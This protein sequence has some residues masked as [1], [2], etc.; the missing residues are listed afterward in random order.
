MQKNWRRGQES[1]LPPD[2]K[3]RTSGFE[4]RDD[5]QARVTLPKMETAKL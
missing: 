2:T 4:D 1:N 5:H 3:C